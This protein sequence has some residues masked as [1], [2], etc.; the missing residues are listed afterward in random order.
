MSEFLIVEKKK[1]FTKHLKD[2]GV[3]VSLRKEILSEYS[4]IKKAAKK[5]K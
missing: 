5:K 4:E 1:D 3:P 2:A